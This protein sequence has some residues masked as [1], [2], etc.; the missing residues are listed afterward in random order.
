MNNKGFILVET[1]VVTIFVMFIFTLLYN[2]AVPL[3]GTYNTLSYYND[4]DVTYDLYHIKKM[5]LK[6]S[7]YSNII[8]NNYKVITC[9][10]LDD[11]NYC[12][13]LYEFLNID[14]VIYLKNENKE[15]LKSN[16]NISNSIKD[17]LDYINIDTDIIIM[18]RDGYVSYLSL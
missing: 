13:Y 4:I 16:N 17:Y 3:L 1:L 2:N 12:N 9:D 10:L 15:E 7:N 14:E 18:E 11:Q 8:E 5:L 6:D